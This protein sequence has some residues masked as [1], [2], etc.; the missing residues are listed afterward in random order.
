MAGYLEERHDKKSKLKWM[1]MHVRGLD[2]FLLQLIEKKQTFLFNSIP[3][4]GF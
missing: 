3:V 1:Y 2:S 4:S